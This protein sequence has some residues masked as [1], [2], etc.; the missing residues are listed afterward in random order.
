MGCRRAKT[1][2]RAPHRVRHGPGLPLPLQQAITP[3]FS[4]GPQPLAPR[5]RWLVLV[6]LVQRPTVV[7]L[8]QCTAVAPLQ[9]TEVLLPLQRTLEL[10]LVQDALQTV[11]FVRRVLCTS[12][13]V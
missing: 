2:S 8:F 13:C 12:R 6:R 9:G 3:V 5:L 11:R 1:R 7:L 4:A 10:Q